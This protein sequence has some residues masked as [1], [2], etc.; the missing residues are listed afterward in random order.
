MHPCSVA[1][2]QAQKGFAVFVA[3]VSVHRVAVSTHPAVAVI[4]KLGL[5]HY[6]TFHEGYCS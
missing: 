6:S 5:V 2:K 4:Q 1:F 3:A